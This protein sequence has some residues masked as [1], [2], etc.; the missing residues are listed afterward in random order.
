MFDYS[1]LRDYPIATPLIQGFVAFIVIAFGAFAVIGIVCAV[2]GI[3]RDN[4]RLQRKDVEN[5]Y[6]RA[7]LIGERRLKTSEVTGVL[8]S[9]GGDDG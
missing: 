5:N 4:E 3:L 7:E 6:K 1:L 8:Y 9:K 2:V